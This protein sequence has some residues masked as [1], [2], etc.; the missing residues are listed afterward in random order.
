MAKV[1]NRAFWR[2]VSAEPDVLELVVG[3]EDTSTTVPQRTATQ[4]TERRP[5][6]VP[7]VATA[8]LLVLLGLGLTVA[9][10]PLYGYTE[11]SAT[12]I[13]DGASYVRAVLPE[14]VR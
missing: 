8:A 7:M 14:G 2:P 13:V 11:R 9:S 12:D 5:L 3:E 1:W 4:T 6:P 10:G